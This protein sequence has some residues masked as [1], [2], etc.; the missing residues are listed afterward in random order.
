MSSSRAISSASSFSHYSSKLW[1]FIQ[2][3]AAHAGTR[4]DRQALLSLVSTDGRLE[5]ETIN[6]SMLSK[7]AINIFKS[8]I[9]VMENRQRLG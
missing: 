7:F 5:S 4:R 1:T 3:V 8:T 6:G 9:A 2:K